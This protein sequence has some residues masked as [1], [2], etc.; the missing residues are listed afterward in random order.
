MSS[1]RRKHS[2][3]WP[4][5]HLYA[6]SPSAT[7]DSEG[8]PTD[9]NAEI[10]FTRV[11]YLFLG[12]E[13]SHVSTVSM[14]GLD[15]LYNVYR[16]YQL[17]LSTFTDIFIDAPICKRCFASGPLPEA[18]CDYTGYAIHRNSMQCYACYAAKQTKLQHLSWCHLTAAAPKLLHKCPMSSCVQLCP[19]PKLPVT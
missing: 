12:L 15:F 14:V 4:L 2:P 5:C 8:S 7:N 16:L 17:I 1:K 10:S 13:Q 18:R 6:C 3:L 19:A 11:F 9:S